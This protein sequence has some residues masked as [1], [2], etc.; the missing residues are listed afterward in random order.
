M[1]KDASMCGLGQTAANPVL[2]TLRYFEDEYMAHIKNKKCPA[3]VCKALIKYLIL[4]DKCTGCMKCI[5]ACPQNAITGERKKV[6]KLNQELC[7]KCG[8]CK[9]TCPFDAII[10]E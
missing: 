8:I 2:S 7:I 6:H 5:K 3:G 1:V 10:V 9:E 4:P